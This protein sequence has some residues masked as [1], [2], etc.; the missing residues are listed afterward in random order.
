MQHGFVRF[1]LGSGQLNRA[2]RLAAGDLAG[3]I[4]PF[5]DGL[6]ERP[7]PVFLAG[8]DYDTPWTR[9][10]AINTFFAGGLL[11]PDVA[12]NTLLSVIERHEGRV[13]I[14]GQYWD[15][16]I[17]A[18]GAW[19][20]WLC[21]SDRDFLQ[22]A[23]DAVAN[24]L[25]RFEAE[26]FSPEFGLF[27][28]AACYAD[29]ISAYPDSYLCDSGSIVDW[30]K[31]HPE[32]AARAG[33]GLPM[34]ALSTNCLYHHAYV[35]A[36]WMAAELGA[37]PDPAW[38]AQA[39][40]LKSAINRQFWM[41]GAG[42][43]RYLVDPFGGADCLETLGQSFAILMGVADPD[44]TSA[45]VRTQHITPQGVPCLWPPYERYT[46]HGDGHVGRQSGT[47]WPHAQGFWALAA[48]RAGRPDLFEA[49]FRK[50]AE[51]VANSHE[52]REVYHPQTGKPYGGLQEAFWR[53]GMLTDSCRRQT[54][55]A[56]A[57]L[58]MV[59]HG[60]FGMRL[61]PGGIRFCPAPLHPP[62][63]VALECVPYRGMELNIGMTGEGPDVIGF[64]VDG[65]EQ[66]EP[67]LA[68]G[69]E[70]RSDIRIVMG[71]S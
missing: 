61:E 17:W 35:L 60:V 20:Y 7:A 57:L 5:T 64:T 69:K 58:G 55:S 67:F 30:P 18:W 51:L 59:L 63:A 46:K 38:A 4:V 40:A 33:F 54:W 3:N 34:H 21:T 12:R 1:E 71:N 22:L 14:G 49:E 15:A 24:S 41:P 2:C 11:F 65:Q 9:D 37:Q 39:E 13:R 70:G 62:R 47:I 27:R 29:G 42:H 25:A 23:L 43:Y 28:G 36:G 26:E 19:Q 53:G 44:R 48:L 6:L 8:M 10:A 16:M 68:A 32:K 50:L 31:R 52:C 56:T 45:I 66:R